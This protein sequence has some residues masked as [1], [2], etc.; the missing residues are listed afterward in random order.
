M[1]D[2]VEEQFVKCLTPECLKQEKWRGICQSCY[3]QAKKLM[4][5]FKLEWE[6]FEKLGMTLI[7]SNK[8]FRKLYLEKRNDITTK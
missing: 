7:Q 2:K 8:P 1:D 5:E 4:E 6:D 3:G